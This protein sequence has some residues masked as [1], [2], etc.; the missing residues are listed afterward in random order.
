MSAY[1]NPI[2]GGPICPPEE[3]ERIAR[4]GHDLCPRCGNE[5]DPEVCWCGD[6]MKGHTPEHMAVPMGCDCGR[7][8]LSDAFKHFDP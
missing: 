8:K 4:L 2:D 3:G 6:P 7:I 1:D 5:I